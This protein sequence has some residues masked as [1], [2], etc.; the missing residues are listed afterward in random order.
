MYAFFGNTIDPTKGKPTNAQCIFAMVEK[1]KSSA[2]GSNS[3]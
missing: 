3:F 1:M 2:N